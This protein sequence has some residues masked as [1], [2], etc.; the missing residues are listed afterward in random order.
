VQTA[1]AEEGE[2]LQEDSDNVIT[3]NGERYLVT[4]PQPKERTE[5]MDAAG[6]TVEVAAEEEEEVEDEVM[7]PVGEES[8][9]FPKK[10]DPTPCCPWIRCSTRTCSFP[11]K[12]TLPSVS[13]TLTLN[14][15]PIHNLTPTD[16]SI[17]LSHAFQTLSKRF[18]NPNPNPNPPTRFPSS[19]FTRSPNAAL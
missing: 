10:N 15:N 12:R 4:K 17:L 3:V 16:T 14:P 8:E 19:L 9:P 1:Q 11:S 2:E 13:C 6:M 18:S 5:V 7:E